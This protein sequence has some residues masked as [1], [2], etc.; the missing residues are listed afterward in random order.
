[1]SIEFEG[2]WKVEIRVS[3]SWFYFLVFTAILRASLLQNGQ[4]L[5]DSRKNWEI[6]T[7]SRK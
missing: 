4:N 6:L 5:V 7:V 3:F 2:K 1:M